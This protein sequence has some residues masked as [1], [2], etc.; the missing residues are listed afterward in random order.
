MQTPISGYFLHAILYP[1]K[2][3]NLLVDQLI[4]WLFVDSGI[5]KFIVP[6]SDKDAAIMA[7]IPFIPYTI[8][9]GR[10]DALF[11]HRTSAGKDKRNPFIPICF[12]KNGAMTAKSG[13]LLPTL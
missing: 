5:V 6:C 11:A 1:A 3:S 13:P 8:S 10:N 9:T 7:T 4:L 2:E 12:K